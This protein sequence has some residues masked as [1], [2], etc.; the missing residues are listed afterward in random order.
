[1]T[2][3][4]E[5]LAGPPDTDENRPPLDRLTTTECVAADSPNYETIDEWVETGVLHLPGVIPEP[6][7]DAYCNRFIKDASDRAMTS[8]HNPVFT[9][10]FYATQRYD[11]ELAT[12]YGIGT[13]YMKV[14]ELRDV[15]LDSRLVEYLDSVH[16][17][18]MGLHLNLTGWK[19][20]QRAWHQDRYLNPTYIGNWYIAAWVALDD[21]EADAGPFEYV[22]GSHR[23]PSIDQAKMLAA[24]GEDGRDPDWPWRSEAIL[25]PLFDREIV[26]RGGHIERF[27]GKKGDVLLW[28]PNLCHRGSVPTD[29]DAERRALIA[30]YSAVGRRRDMPN[31]DR[32]TN[33]TADGIYF[34][35]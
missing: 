31:I 24:M 20:T 18:E 27:L 23:W 28:H 4:L 15:C 9:D 33:D 10:S 30:H 22:P 8:L 11:E 12:G 25:G 19:S 7:I 13:P 16:G 6:V 35:L 21:V 26:N 1:M 32:W 2:L 3:T 5:D 34:V 17:V 14:P 29:P